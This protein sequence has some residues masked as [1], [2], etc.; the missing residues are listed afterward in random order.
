MLCD[1]S[2]L[3]IYKNYLNGTGPSQELWGY[4]ELLEKKD[5]DIQFLPYKKFKWVNKLGNLI[6]FS[7]LD[8]QLI[9]LTK[10][11]NAD[12]II[13]VTAGASSKLILTLKSIGLIQTPIIAFVHWPMLGNTSNSNLVKKIGKKWLFQYDKL[14]YV[15]K[16][17]MKH[18]IKVFKLKKEDYI[19]KFIHMDWG[20]QTNFYHINEHIEV[21][22]DF[23]VSV[24]KSQRDF[25]TL[26]AAF[27]KTKMKLK[28]YPGPNFTPNIKIIPPNIEIID[29]LVPYKDLIQV[30]HQAKF[31]LI[32]L[33]NPNLSTIGLTSL[34]DVL[35]IGKPVIMTKNI[36]VDI[37]VEASG[38]GYSVDVGDVDG[39]ITKINTLK[40]D[41]ALCLEMG[42]NARKL[43]EE[44]YNMKRFSSELHKILLEY[45]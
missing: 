40:E 31:I 1:Y 21:S 28:I 29:R 35:A 11:N 39:W 19:D 20:S 17:I 34:M 14:I 15:S 30:Y 8:Q 4:A 44:K 12:L 27:S 24:G 32:C 7:H 2:L 16:E 38:V 43:H 13:E 33:Q 6:G 3:K 22:E 23:A 25:D 5:F 37:D 10:L 9:L 36:F 42:R 18:N 26:I 41:H 45:K